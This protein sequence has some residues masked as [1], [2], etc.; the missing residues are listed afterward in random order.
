MVWGESGAP[1]EAAI[2][3]FAICYVRRSLSRVNLTTTRHKLLRLLF[4]PQAQRRLLIDLFLRRIFPHVLRDL[5]GA[6]M[7]AAHGTEVR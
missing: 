6:E 1:I 2:K 7:R 4:H 3:Q 5:H